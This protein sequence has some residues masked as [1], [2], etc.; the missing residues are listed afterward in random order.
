MKENKSRNIFKLIRREE[1]E[2]RYKHLV[3]Y[4]N[5]HFPSHNHSQNISIVIVIGIVMV[6][7]YASF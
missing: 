1:N 7:E 5:N 4:D 2:G 3:N 6:I